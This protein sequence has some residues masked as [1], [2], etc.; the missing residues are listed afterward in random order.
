MIY[1]ILIDENKFEDIK[2][3][4][5]KDIDYLKN[6][7]EKIKI[8]NDYTKDMLFESSDNIE[9]IDEKNDID[10]QILQVAYDN[11]KKN[12]INKIYMSILGVIMSIYFIIKK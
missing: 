12:I 10:V 9:K 3:V 6:E 1:N 7:L 5:D 11:K 4:D 2:I 8:I